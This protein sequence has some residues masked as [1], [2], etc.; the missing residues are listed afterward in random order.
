M[1]APL[2]LM[3][4]PVTR[5][6]WGAFVLALGLLVLVLHLHLLLALL[7]ALATY[8]LYQALVTWLAR[9]MGLRLAE[10]LTLGVVAAAAV[11]LVWLLYLGV[12]ELHEAY[13]SGRIDSLSASVLGTIH[14]FD[15]W[16]PIWLQEKLPQSPAEAQQL[17][18]QWSDDHPERLKT[19]GQ[20]TGRAAAH[21][22]I[23]VVIGFLAGASPL[24]P[25]QGLSAFTLAWRARLQQLYGAFGD[26]VAAQLRIS[27]VNT[28]LTA[29]FLLVLLPLL[30]YHLPLGFTLVL[31]TFVAGLLPIIG[32]L[33]S[34]TAI[35]LVALTIS[36][37]M[38]V[39]AL[40]FLIGVHKLEYFINAKIMGHKLRVRTYE[41]LAVMLVMEAAFGLG[42][43]VA[44]PV[45]YAWLTRELRDLRIF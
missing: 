7:S 10:A 38:A 32:N 40:L 18:L 21:L 41:L 13:R 43:L 39:A 19:A 4:S 35:T 9:R 17:L 25:P 15:A 20:W 3:P 2:P 37:W 11:L 1:S 16:L 45:Y 23:G 36:P 24:P 12:A 31:I 34:N 42:G 5:T 33:L 28:V 8:S 44:A 6:Q 27:A 29:L 14:H 30:G 22:F 26:V